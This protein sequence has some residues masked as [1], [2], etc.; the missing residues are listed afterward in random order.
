MIFDLILPGL[1]TL[2]FVFG[3]P[4]AIIAWTK[5]DL[6]KKKELG[7]LFATALAMAIVIVILILVLSKFLD[8]TIVS[9]IITLVVA[10]GSLA[11]NWYAY[12]KRK[13]K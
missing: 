12:K 1:I 8:Q 9:F 4:F 3:L 2:V 13:N 6:P 11:V 5:T 10:G 7:Q